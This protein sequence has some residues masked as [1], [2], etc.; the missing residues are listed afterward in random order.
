[1]VKV[2]A[3]VSGKARWVIKPAACKTL[4]NVAA[5]KTVRTR[6][7]IR[8]TRKARGSYAVRVS[9]KGPGINPVNSNNKIKVTK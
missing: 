6:L 4:R 7:A 9:A 5:G 2:C 8:T 3:T 1:M